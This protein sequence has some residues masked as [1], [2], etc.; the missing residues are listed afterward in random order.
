MSLISLGINAAK[1]I[2]RKAAGRI[3]T[4]GKHAKTEGLTREVKEQQEFLKNSDTSFRKYNRSTKMYEPR[5]PRGKKKESVQYQEFLKELNSQN[6]T[7]STYKDIKQTQKEYE[8]ITGEP[9]SF[10]QA[11]TVSDIEKGVSTE[12]E[13]KE[14]TDSESLRAAHTYNAMKFSKHMTEA[15][16][17]ALYNEL[18]NSNFD[19]PVNKI[20][21]YVSEMDERLGESMND[22]GELF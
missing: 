18:V 7:M 5:V 8:Q 1:S 2:T 4:F 17:K 12:N 6:E 20:Y 3:K 14:G 22:W 21:E 15:D 16:K 13:A 9:I 19:I 11:S 10:Q